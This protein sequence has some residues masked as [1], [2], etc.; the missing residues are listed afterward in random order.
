[1]Q[2]NEQHHTSY[3]KNCAVVENN[4]LEHQHGHST[5]FTTLQITLKCILKIDS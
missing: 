2:Y 1:M 4:I 3:R 5:K